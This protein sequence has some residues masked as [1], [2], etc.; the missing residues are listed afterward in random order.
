MANQPQKIDPIRTRY[1]HPL[2]QAEAYS[3]GLFWIVAVFSI[4]ALALERARYPAIYDVVQGG[5]ILGVLG[6]FFLGQ[7]VRLYW[8]PRA[9]D[10]RRQDLLSNSFA[11]AITHEQTTGYYNNEQTNP[12]RRLCQPPDLWLDSTER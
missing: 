1:Y 10:K 3:D 9:E 4:S 6:L 5:F 12:L 8:T 2:E 7:G 11:V